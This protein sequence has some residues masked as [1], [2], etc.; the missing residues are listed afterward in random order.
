MRA[1]ARCRPRLPFVHARFASTNGT[2]KVWSS[3]D[4]AVSD[5]P[6]G[7]TLTVGGF[8]LCGIPE[9]L[10][11]ALVKA[12]PQDLTA[13]SNNAGVD[14]F[15]L[16]LLL[17]SGQVK[18]MISSY[19]GEN[20]N[21]ERM[22]LNGELEVE[23]TPQG[24]LAER[25]RA[26]G[27][28]I[29]AFFTPTAAGT[30]I[31]D[32]GFPIKYGAGGAASGDVEVAG[33]GRESREFDGRKYVMERAIKGDFALIKAHK[34]DT[35]GNLIFRRTA[36]N[37]NPACAKAA[38]VCIAEVEEVVEVGEM[39]PDSVH[40]SGLYVDRVVVA[41]AE[42]R[43]ER[44][45]VSITRASHPP[46]TSCHLASSLLAQVAG[47]NVGF[48]PDPT[49]ERIIKR[50]ARELQDGMHATR[51]NLAVVCR[52]SMRHTAALCRCRYVNLGIG[53]PTLAVNH[54]PEG[55]RVEMQSENGLVGAGPYPE[56]S[57]V[58]PDLINA[59]KE[60]V[61]FLPG[62]SLCSSDESFA[63]IRGAH[64]DL[65][66]LGALQVAPTGDLANWVIPGKMVKGM[67]GAMDLVSSGTRVVV[68]MEHTAKGGKHKILPA[69]TLPLTGKGVIDRLITEMGVF[70]FDKPAGEMVLVELD[71]STTLEELR[72]ATSA[73]FRVAD[74][75]LNMA[76]GE[77][78][79]KAC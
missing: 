59:S 57:A 65:T 32:G 51:P 55:V 24:T 42:K 7:A 35:R 26:G 17:K 54:V 8:G 23:L 63:M 70:D 71:P 58:D 45:T 20:K 16:D 67:G 68:T 29:P 15:G 72:A 75:L 41:T 28:G 21:F 18:K 12:G 66:I 48:K 60:T 50:A 49:R 13:V 19:V 47:A 30:V 3:V 62:A 5:I 74:T 33:P 36:R 25:L 34:A 40:L 79:E 76:T 10:I 64:M 4:A 52:A 1:L 2:S 53:I 78:I 6:S 27:A 39:D 69:C 61:T 43:I 38:A 9:N 46:G 31:E 37:F 73:N 56:D 14:D 44:R 77:P 22:Y 11:A